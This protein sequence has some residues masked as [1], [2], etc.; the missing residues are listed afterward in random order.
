MTVNGENVRDLSKH[1][2]RVSL[3]TTPGLRSRRCRKWR[4]SAAA[5]PS[6]LA[7]PTDRNAVAAIPKVEECVGERSR[8]LSAS[9]VP[10]QR[11]DREMPG[12]LCHGSRRLLSGKP[13]AGTKK[14][15]C[16][17]I[18]E[19]SCCRGRNRRRSNVASGDRFARVA[20]TDAGCSACFPF[21]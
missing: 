5:D 18:P 9:L 21:P 2:M 19:I 12:G 4:D 16:G 10:A 14:S 7:Q 17:L 20:S 13:A 11:T 8:S 15:A 1:P 6:S 3:A